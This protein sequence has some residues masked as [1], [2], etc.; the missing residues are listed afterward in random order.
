MITDQITYKGYRYPPEIIS[1]AVWLYYR[2]CLSYRDVEDLLAER[3]IIVS[4]ETVRQWCG[5]FGPSY[6]RAV[7][8]VQGVLGDTWFLD[9]VFVTIQGRRQYLWR[10]V[11]QDGDTLD[12]L[13]QNRRD[14]KAA[15]R[16]FRKLLKE[17]C[18]VPRWLVTDK[19]KSYSAAR[20]T[21]L[22][23]VV[24]VTER[25]ANNRAEVSHEPTRQREYQMRRFK[26]PGQAQRF[27]AVHAVVGNLFRLGRHLT[28]ATHY[29]VFRARAFAQWQELTYA[30]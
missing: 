20:R 15:E 23:S 12:I 6:A 11:D 29:R 24:H 27:L 16:F 7:K 18:T 30:R 19:L 4:Y 21:T 17:Q 28:R 22:A 5:K 13:V 25:Y 10:A 26:S 1:Q 3:G 8:R 14:R 9:E 2:F